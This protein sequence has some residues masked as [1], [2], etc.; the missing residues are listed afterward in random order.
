VGF[1]SNAF[2]RHK[3]FFAV[4]PPPFG[5]SCC[6]NSL[7]H[8]QRLSLLFFHFELDLLPQPPD[9]IVHLIR[10]VVV[11]SFFFSLILLSANFLFASYSTPSPKNPLIRCLWGFVTL[12]SKIFLFF[13]FFQAVGCPKGP[14]NSPVSVRPPPTCRGFADF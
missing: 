3:F 9:P 8:D 14:C 2:G 11:E 13:H 12:V 1:L 6:A 5:L 10:W 7:G 4:T